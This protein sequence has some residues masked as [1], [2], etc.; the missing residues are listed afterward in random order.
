MVFVQSKK[1][2]VDDAKLEILQ[3]F[4]DSEKHIRTLEFVTLKLDEITRS[5]TIMKRCK[6]LQ[7]TRFP[8]RY[9][10]IV[11]EQF[12]P[13]MKTLK[14]RH[15]IL[16]LDGPSQ[17]GKTTFCKQL[18]KNPDKD[19]VEIDC[20]GLKTAPNFHVSTDSTSIICW[21]EVGP[22]ICLRLP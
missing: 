15:K 14:D 4:K 1:M 6:D 19:Y 21:G 7:K 10:R 20:S 17:V 13:H 22:S 3:T 9:I 16:V 2:S 11:D 18:D 5:E 12:L 8:R